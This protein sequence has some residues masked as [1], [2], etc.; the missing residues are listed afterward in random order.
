MVS[1]QPAGGA[2]WGASP[3]WNRPLEGAAWHPD[4]REWSVDSMIVWRRALKMVLD[5][6]MNFPHFSPVCSHLHLPSSEVLEGEQKSGLSLTLFPRKQQ[7]WWLKLVGISLWSV[8]FSSAVQSLSRDLHSAVYFR[9]QCNFLAW[10]QRLRGSRLR[11]TS[12]RLNCSPAAPNWTV[13]GWHCLTCR[14]PT[15]PSQVTK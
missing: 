5:I 15:K 13:C 3:H 10:K 11:R 7:W 9:A 6:E 2:L 1:L 14:T 12:Y 8:I 4:R